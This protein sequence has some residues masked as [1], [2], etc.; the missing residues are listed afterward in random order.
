MEAMVKKVWGF[1]G[2]LFKYGVDAQYNGDNEENTY[3]LL[4]VFTGFSST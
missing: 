1:K 2:C 4:K 3:D